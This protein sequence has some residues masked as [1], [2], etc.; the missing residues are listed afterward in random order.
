MSER[1]PAARWLKLCDCEGQIPLGPVPRNFFVEMLR[2]SRQIVSLQTRYEEVTRKL[3]TSRGSYEELVPV[4]FGLYRA[5]AC[6][7]THGLAVATLSVSTSVGLPVRQT[8]GLWQKRNNRL[9][10]YQTIR[11]SNVSGFL[12]PNFMFLS[13]GVP[14]LRKSVLKRGTPYRKRKFDQ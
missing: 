11:Q 2:G 1:T 4:E 8:H 7:A 14:P 5:T 9:S 10:T 3:T 12:K 6:N 13:L